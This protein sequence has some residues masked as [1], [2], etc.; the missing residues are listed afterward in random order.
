[1]NK[2]THDNI[3]VSY[4]HLD[5]Y[6]RQDIYQAI[7]ASFVLSRLDLSLC[8]RFEVS[9]TDKENLPALTEIIARKTKVKKNCRNPPNYRFL[10]MSVM[11]M[12]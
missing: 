1:M 12:C 2:Q 11:N 8:E 9:V 4:T 7:Y 5:V 6:K 10:C 3:P